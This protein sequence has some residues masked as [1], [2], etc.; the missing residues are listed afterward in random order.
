MSVRAALPALIVAVLI[1]M[2]YFGLQRNPGVIPSPFIGKPAPDFNLEDLRDPERRV[3]LAD[4]K[5]QP[6]ALNVWGTWCVGCRQEHTT[7]MRISRDAG[8]PLIGMNWRDERSAA[9]SYLQ[10]SGDPFNAIGRDESGAAA[11]DWGVYGA[12]ETFLVDAG[13]TV[14]YK[15]I[16]PLDYATW[17]REFV[18]RVDGVQRP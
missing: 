7:L 10:Q 8:L 3:R 6:F 1:V 2:F 11:I 17:Q 12:P 4:F 9:L 14:V 5:G 13:G 15:H 18:G 16:G